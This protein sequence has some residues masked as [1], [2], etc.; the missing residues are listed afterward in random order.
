[1]YVIDVV[2]H[3]RKIAPRD[4][5][6]LGIKLKQDAGILI[7]QMVRKKFEASGG[8]LVRVFDIVLNSEDEVAQLGPD[9]FSD[10]QVLIPPMRVMSHCFGQ[11]KTGRAIFSSVGKSI[12]IP[13]LG[14]TN[15]LIEPA[16]YDPE[17]RTFVPLSKGADHLD[18]SDWEIMTWHGGRKH[19][20]T[21]IEE[22]GNLLIPLTVFSA[23]SVDLFIARAF[24]YKN[25]EQLPDQPSHDE[26]R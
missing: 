17:S 10:N 2:R 21:P 14:K 26:D 12:K 9:D 19:M 15:N 23:I 7:G 18:R 24:A 8:H 3:S 1:M 16:T 22:R 4:G 13:E 20:Q 11:P 6:L 5:A 25:G